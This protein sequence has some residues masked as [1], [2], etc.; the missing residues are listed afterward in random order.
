MCSLGLQVTLVH[1]FLANLS[2]SY[3]IRNYSSVLCYVW[4]T[5]EQ[6]LFLLRAT[7]GPA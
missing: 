4:L 6:E 7:G 5:P 1:L 2:T 3:V